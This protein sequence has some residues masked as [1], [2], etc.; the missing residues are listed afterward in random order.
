MTGHVYPDRIVI[1][2]EVPA[3][4]VEAF[5]DTPYALF[6]PGVDAAL[7]RFDDLKAL[8]VDLIARR[9]GRGLKVE[10]GALIWG[11]DRAEMRAS[12]RVVYSLR[13]GS[14]DQVF[15]AL[16]WAERAGHLVE[17]LRAAAQ[18]RPK[19]QGGGVLSGASA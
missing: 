11:E 12:I 3:A 8:A 6:E 15:T 2:A 7:T 16:C 18:A 19:P 13:D 14:V 1:L 9:G 10:D 5:R 4:M 17:A